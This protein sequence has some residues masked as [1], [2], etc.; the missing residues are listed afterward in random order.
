MGD[1]SRTDN[2]ARGAIG[3]ADGMSFG[4]VLSF[5]LSD[6]LYVRAAAS[7]EDKDFTN[8]I[9]ST[10]TNL[11]TSQRFIEAGA[12][13]HMEVD[14]ETDIYAEL[15]AMDTRVEHGLPCIKNQSGCHKLS[16]SEA[17][18]ELGMYGQ[19]IA[20]W[21]M[22]R[23]G[24]PPP[25]PL[26][27]TTVGILEDQGFGAKLGLRYRLSAG[28]ELEGSLRA[29]R[30]VDENDYTLGFAARHRLVDNLHLGITVSFARSTD[31]N[32]DNIQK[33]GLLLRHEF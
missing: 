22:N 13:F 12:G 31:R 5:E 17:R 16:S 7:T 11:D 28:L 27:S 14:P 23:M 20:A 15:I 1:V 21:S 32:F 10:R 3:N 8:D 4:A 29:N 30:I 19:A 9:F 24:P 33:M 2:T 18:T 6:S 26:V 25:R